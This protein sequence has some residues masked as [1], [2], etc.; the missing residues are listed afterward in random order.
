MAL[1]KKKILSNE[2]SELK[3]KGE[4]VRITLSG[5][6]RWSS[7]ESG[8]DDTSPQQLRMNAHENP[9]VRYPL[10]LTGLSSPTTVMP[11]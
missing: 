2:Q 8:H 6:K 10:P 11:F 3:S 9:I 1:F 5:F 7:M 4:N